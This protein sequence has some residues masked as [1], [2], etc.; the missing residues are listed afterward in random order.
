MLGSIEISLLKDM[1]LPTDIVSLCIHANEVLCDN[2]YDNELVQTHSRIRCNEIIPAILYDKIAKAYTPFKNSN[3]KKKLSIPQD[4]VIK[5]I[6]KQ[7]TVE[8][9]DSLN[10]LLEL[11]T[12][13]GVSTKGFRGINLEQSYSVPKRCYDDSMIGVIGPSSSPDGNVGVNRSLTM[14]PNIKTAR[15][16]IEVKKDNLNEV[17]DVNL[18][19]PAELLIPLGVTRDDPVRT[20]HS[21]KQSR[22]TIPVVKSS[23]VLISNGS[24]EMCKYYLSSDF[25]V[26]AKMDGKVVENDPSTKIMVV[27]YK[28]GTHQAIDFEFS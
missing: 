15:G 2:Q 9:Y 21:V 4:C 1:N 8:D 26:N 11:E 23:P 5:E 22:H 17:K 28:D 25:V 6:L 16:Y 20:G 12:N 7:K 3:G 10:P 24:D 14:E 27:E 18:F 13:H 19:S